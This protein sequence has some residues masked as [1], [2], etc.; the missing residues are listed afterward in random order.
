MGGREKT[1]QVLFFTRVTQMSL[2]PRSC[3]MWKMGTLC[4][5]IAGTS[6]WKQ[7]LKQ[8]LRKRMRQLLTRWDISSLP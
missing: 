3:H 8:T 7:T 1:H 6:V 2:C 5:L 4:S